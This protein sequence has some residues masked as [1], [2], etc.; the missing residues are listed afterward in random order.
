MFYW[1]GGADRVMDGD[2]NGSGASR[3]G[4]RSPVVPLRS[5][6]IVFSNRKAAAAVIAAVLM[7][8][9][10]AAPA[11]AVE[12]YSVQADQT[13]TFV[14]RGYGHGR[15]M[16]QYGAFHA[17]SIGHSA[18]QITDRYYSGSTVGTVVERAAPRAPRAHRQ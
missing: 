2:W 11:E 17:A 5:V 14:G 16:S 9:L 4:V 13:Y 6:T 12:D 3:V 8:P 7:L 1:G 10:W 18:R 15:G